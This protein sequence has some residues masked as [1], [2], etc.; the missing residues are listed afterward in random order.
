MSEILPGGYAVLGAAAMAAGVTRTFSPQTLFPNPT[1]PLPLP[2]PLPLTLTI[3]LP[4]P[5]VTRTISSAIVVFELTGGLIYLL[6]L[7][8]TPNPNPSLT[9]ITLILGGLTHVLPLLLAVMVAYMTAEVSPPSA[10]RFGNY[11]QQRIYPNL[12]PYDQGYSV[13]IFDSILSAKGLITMFEFKDPQTWHR[14][15]GDV[16]LVREGND[17]H[18]PT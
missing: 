7:R 14:T 5:Q 8:L 10:S 9:L 15:A 18:G 2:L 12:N 11:T 4:L 17:P 13:S 3:N 16:M 6:P 1:L